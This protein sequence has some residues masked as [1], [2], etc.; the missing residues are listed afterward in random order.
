MRIAQQ[1]LAID[2]LAVIRNYCHYFFKTMCTPMYISIYL[3]I[4]PDHA[5]H[6]RLEAGVDN[7]FVVED[8]QQWRNQ[9][10]HALQHVTSHIIASVTSLMFVLIGREVTLPC[11]YRN[12][13][14]RACTRSSRNMPK[15]HICIY[16]NMYETLYYAISGQRYGRKKLSVERSLRIEG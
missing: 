1:Q 12:C 11:S 8:D 4:L 16:I 9:V 5:L 10:T 14:T 6:D 7:G 2:F 3:Y 13:L 15:I